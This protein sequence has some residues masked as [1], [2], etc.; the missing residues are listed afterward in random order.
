MPRPPK[1]KTLREQA[2][3]D[4]QKAIALSLQESQG[5]QRNGYVPATSSSWPGVSEPP[6]VDPSS[7]PKAG[8]N[9]EEDD[10]ELRAAIEASLR[11]M[12]APLPSAPAEVDA[13]QVNDFSTRVLTRG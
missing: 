5:H 8:A 1:P 13:P 7:R 4:L 9:D 2:D 6:V 11:E 10:P 3:E 12:Q